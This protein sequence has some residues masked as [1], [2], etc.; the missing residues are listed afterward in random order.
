M[1]VLS[2]LT[3]SRLAQLPRTLRVEWP[4][5]RVGAAAAPVRLRVR[6]WRLLAWLARGEIGQLAQAYVDGR[7]DIEGSLDDVMAVAG[8]LAG[9]PK[10]VGL[11]LNHGIT[12]A[13][14]RNHG[15]GAGMGDLIGK[16]IFA[17]GEWVHLAEVAQSMAGSAL[18]LQRGWLSLLQLLAA[19]SDPM[20]DGGVLPGA[21][22][23]YPFRRRYRYG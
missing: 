7:L 15:L 10:P 23:A 22:S 4:G 8:A 6:G 17:G 16:R 21:G 2:A 1:A 5:D 20:V 9:L 11:V 14:L 12:A 18:C 3:D 19:R 13:G